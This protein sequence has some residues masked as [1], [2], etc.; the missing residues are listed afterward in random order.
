MACMHTLFRHS[1]ILCGGTGAI[2]LLVGAAILTMVGD[3]TAGT[4]RAGVSAGAAGTAVAGG[5]TITTITTI[6][7]VGIT[8]TGEV[9]DIGEMP[10]PIGALTVRAVLLMPETECH[11]PL[12]VVLPR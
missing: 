4:V 1:P 3:G 8:D 2:T 11:L 5:D 9:A 12:P 7:P 10:I 6:I